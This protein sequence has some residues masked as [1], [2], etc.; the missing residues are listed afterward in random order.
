MGRMIYR[1][2]PAGGMGQMPG[3]DLNR[4]KLALQSNRPDEAVRLLRKW[5][6]RRPNDYN[7]RLLLAQALLQTQ[8]IE[9]GL[10]EARRVT[11]EQPRNS[12]A[13]LLLAAALTQRQDSASRQEAETAARRAVELQP[14]S[15]R[16]RVQLAEVLAA[17]NNLKDAH[18]EADEAVRLEPRLPAAHLIRAMILL[19]DKDPA[20]AVA[21]AESALR[22]DNTQFAA[23]FTLANALVEVKRYDEALA[24]LNRA[25]SLN[26]LLPVS[27]LDGLRGR[28]YLK[29]RKFPAAYQQFLQAG[30]SSGRLAWLAPVTAAVSMTQYFGRYAPV[31]VIMLIIAAILFGLGFIPYAGPW[32]VVVLLLGLLGVSFFTSIRQFQGSLLPRGSARIP[33]LVTMVVVGVVIFGVVLWL[34]HSIARLP[35]ISIN[36]VILFIA[37]ILAIGAAAGIDYLWPRIGRL[38][39]RLPGRPRAVTPAS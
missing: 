9:E 25:Q 2:G 37:G 11:R 31:V 7:A 8:Q 16:A 10:A 17:R 28:I 12:D 20:G 6:D 35:G 24:A 36:V 39:A 34:G 22:Y 1:G 33:A 23:H 27:N 26:P 30:R 3:G 18:T 14:K 5:V 21:A 29:Q 19:S 15:G 4:A 32:I 38:A 13:F